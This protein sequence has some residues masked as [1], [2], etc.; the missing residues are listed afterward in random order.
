MSRGVEAEIAMRTQNEYTRFDVVRGALEWRCLPSLIIIGA[1][2]CGSTALTGFLLHHSQ[3]RFGKHKELHYFDKNESQCMGTI[4]YLLA[5]PSTQQTLSSPLPFATSEA[6][7]F[8]LAATHSCQRI[9]EQ[10]PHAK[11]IVLVRDPI[12]RAKSEYSMKER[13]VEA[14]DEFSTLLRSPKIIKRLVEC[15]VQVGGRNLT[16]GLNDCGPR[17]LVSN[18][19]FSLFKA[20]ILRQLR[21]IHTSSTLITLTEWL[22]KCFITRKSSGKDDNQL[23]SSIFQKFF[24]QQEDEIDPFS[25]RNLF[26]K[27]NTCYPEGSRERLAGSLAQVLLDEISY[28]ESCIQTHFPHWPTLAPP[29][30]NDAAKFISTC[31][32]VRTGISIQYVYR[33]LYAAQLQ[34]CQNYIP[35]SNILVLENHNLRTKT[36][37]SLDSIADFLG[38]DHVSYDTKL[39]DSTSDALQNAIRTKYPTF[40]KTGWRLQGTEKEREYF[41]PSVLSQLVSFFAPHNELLFSMIQ[42]RFDHWYSITD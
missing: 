14:Q 24:M 5:F 33:G 12:E 30:P 13:R 40:E 3:L 37:S 23:D 10:L 38:I 2:K 6:T 31:V 4:P 8:Y 22:R 20:S 19:K 35:Q 16:K 11:I 34:R 42:E 1:Q 28:Y 39:F 25:P 9:T 21:A 26:F 36:Q 18:A 41:K 7:P 15:L 32:H 27:T 29:T 17:E